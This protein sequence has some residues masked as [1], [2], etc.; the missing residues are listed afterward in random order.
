MK[1]VVVE[2]AAVTKVVVVTITTSPSE[3][4]IICY[5]A[6]QLINEVKNR[7]FPNRITKMW[8]LHVQK[9][10]SVIVAEDKTRVMKKTRIF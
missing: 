4:V 1:V 7:P 9:N 2:L 8:K 10:P 5:I 6:F 3:R